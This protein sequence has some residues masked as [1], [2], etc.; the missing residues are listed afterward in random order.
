AGVRLDP[1]CPHVGMP[2]EAAEATEREQL[3][4]RKDPEGVEDRVEAGDVMALG[5][6]EDVALRVVPAD[7][8]G[9]QPLEEEMDEEVERAEGRAEVPRARTLDGDE[10]VQPAHVAEQSEAFVRLDLG[11]PHAVELALRDELEH[12]H[13]A[14]HASAHST[15]E[16]HLARWPRSSERLKRRRSRQPMERRT[17]CGNA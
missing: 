17:T 3:L 1:R 13:S 9:V 2:V 15:R 16:A 10:S 8:R 12:R 5:G 4:A 7:L 6:E 11:R 14:W